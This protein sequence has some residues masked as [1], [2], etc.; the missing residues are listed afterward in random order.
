MKRF[1]IPLILVLITGLAAGGCGKGRG[2]VAAVLDHGFPLAV[3][4]KAVIDKTSLEIRFEEI[5]EDS[6]C[7]EG[8][9]CIWEGRVSARVEIKDGDSSYKMVLV[10]PGSTRD[11]VEETYKE[12][13]LSYKITPYPQQNEDIDKKDYRLLLTVSRKD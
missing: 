6:R 9:Q 8:V 12:Y 7:P 5:L 11:Y 13:L 2:E 10:Q 1:L 3:G 4:Q